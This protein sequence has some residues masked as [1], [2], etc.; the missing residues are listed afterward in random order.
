MPLALPVE[1]RSAKI[2]FLRGSAVL[3]MLITHI[4]VV[5]AQEYSLVLDKLTWWG[6]TVCFSIFLF[7]F[8]YIYGLKLTENKKLN[9]E[10]Q[11]KRIFLLLFIYYV[12]A[13]FG[14]YLLFNSVSMSEFYS[15][16]IFR[17]LPVFT[18]FL[19][20]FFLYAI[21][22]LIFSSVFKKLLQRPV[23]FILISFV[24][25]FLAGWLYT[26]DG[27][28][29]FVTVLKTL[30]VGNGHVHSYGILSYFPIF[31]L[32][33]VAGGM[34]N[35]NKDNAGKLAYL[36]ILM[37]GLILFV[38]LRI[39]GLSLWYRFPPS[40]LFLLYGI[41]YSF[42]VVL[43]YKYIKKVSIL[44][45]YFVFLGKRALFIFLINVILILGLSRS[46]HYEK[47]AVATVWLMQFCIIIS[48]TLLTYLYEKVVVVWRRKKV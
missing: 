36:P 44:N 9:V 47:F 40:I 34:Q 11:V 21:L 12:A 8:A 1:E 42:G 30:M 15:I 22:I 38:F 25:Y 14:H 26:L 3:F 5:F 41:I 20:P 32:G 6:A 43:L 24:V 17:Y 10:K 4:N 28:G 2:D 7:C 46:L 23:V 27:G 13:F 45:R 35:T 48:I 37:L 18:E 29:S 39:S 33:L 31:V 16:L 19:V